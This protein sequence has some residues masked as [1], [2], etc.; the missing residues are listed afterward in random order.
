MKYNILK[1]SSI[2]FVVFS[3]LFSFFIVLVNAGVLTT[4]LS[5]ANDGVHGSKITVTWFQGA[6]QINLGPDQC[7]LN[8]IPGDNVPYA[9]KDSDSSFQPKE[10]Y[11][12]T[13]CNLCGGD[14]A[15]NEGLDPG[16]ENY[17]CDP[18]GICIICDACTSGCGVGETCDTSQGTCNS[19]CVCDP[20]SCSGSE[21]VSSTTLRV[22]SGCSG[23]SC[24]YNEGTC[25]LGCFDKSDGTSEYYSGCVTS[26]GSSQCDTNPIQYE[27][28]GCEN[29]Y[30]HSYDICICNSLTGECW[31]ETK[32]EIVCPGD[33]TQSCGDPNTCSCIEI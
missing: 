14:S 6:D 17:Y 32:T 27:C 21:C 31:T 33:E 3:V 5:P 7:G 12:P 26:G 4:S 18:S 20:A 13:A 10:D 9:F 2:F 15:C 22:Y 11:D 28:S 1:Y 19:Q 23:T 24:S 30:T 8:G 25:L 16:V 29:K